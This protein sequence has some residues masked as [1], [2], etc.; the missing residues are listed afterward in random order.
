MVEEMGE[1]FN[2][3]RHRRRTEARLVIGG[4]LILLVVGGGLVWGFY[5]RGAALTAVGCLLV[6]AVVV[7]LLWLLLGLLE[8]WVSDDAP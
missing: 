1:R 6:M 3:D 5:G 7:S 8:R 2:R 4:Y